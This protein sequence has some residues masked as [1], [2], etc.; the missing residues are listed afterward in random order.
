MGMV[1]LG[2][3]LI[4]DPDGAV[5]SQPVNGRSTAISFY[6]LNDER[7]SIMQMRKSWPDRKCGK[8]VLEAVLESPDTSNR[9]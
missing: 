2:N 5:V 7:G 3:S 8:K 4:A 9:C 6:M 1:S